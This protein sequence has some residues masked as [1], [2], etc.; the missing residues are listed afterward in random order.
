MKCL[1][2]I[3]PSSGTKTIQKNLD[4]MIGQMILKQIVQTIDV[5][6]TQKRRCLSA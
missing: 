4:Q 2:I 5:F 1:F 6:Y 3:N